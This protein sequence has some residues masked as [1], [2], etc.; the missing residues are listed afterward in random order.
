MKF[1]STT[2]GFS[3]I[4]VMIAVLILSVAITGLVQGITTA[5]RSTKDSE[6]Q[7]T[8]AFFAA[9]QIEILRAEGF[10]DDGVSEGKGPA[11][12]TAYQWKQTVSPTAIPGLH[13]VAVEVRHTS[14][15][16]PIIE[17]HTLLFDPPTGSVTNR[18]DLNEKSS[19]R[20]GSRR[21]AP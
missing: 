5:L 16:K 7:T 15:T 1:R 11:G 2:A 19:R 6:L 14:A 3:L 8:A 4:E 17:L 10:R 20:R 18:A 12:L 13:E 21:S 9:G